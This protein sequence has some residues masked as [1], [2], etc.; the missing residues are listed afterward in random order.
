MAT[1]R[2]RLSEPGEELWNC[3]K[4]Y[5]LVHGPRKGGKSLAIADKLIRNALNYP[6]SNTCI[7]TRTI[8]KGEAG[9][10]RNI[11]K[12]GGMLSKWQKAGL[13]KY[14][15]R[16][17][18]KSGPS[19]RP[20]S[21]VPFFELATSGDPSTF[22]MHTLAED[23]KVEDKFKDQLY[24]F[25]YLVEADSFEREVYT[26]MRMC[27]R[28]T[29]VPY[30]AQQ[31]ILDMNPPAEGKKHWAYKFIENPG[32]DEI[33]IQFPIEKNCFLQPQEREDIRS[34]YAHDPNKLKRF[35]HGEWVEMAEGSCFSDVFNENLHVVGEELGADSDY[36]VL[37][38]MSILR[39]W[40]GSYQYDLG[41]D[42]GD[43]NTS[44]VL[45]SPRQQGNVLCYDILDEVLLLRAPATMDEFVGMVMKMQNYWT[46]WM[47]SEN[48]IHQPM[49]RHWSDSSSM[50]KRMALSGSEAKLVYDLSGGTISLCG[51][52]K[53]RDSVEQRKNMLR[54]LLYENKIA[55]SSRC[56]GIISMLKHLPPKKSKVLRD[57]LSGKDVFVQAGVDGDSRWKHPFDA[58]TY[59]LAQCFPMHLTDGAGPQEEARSLTMNL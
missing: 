37:D 3:R 2:P 24:D 12:P 9:V 7:L 49:F 16:K 1:W 4:R 58:L 21:K 41:W 30:H 40:E 54:R 13:A 44:V 6:G 50:N 48:K 26:T 15:S 53:G 35:F 23:E 10:W 52:T 47:R 39:P 29:V 19:Y 56:T 51:V 28:S 59:S 22:E 14:Y 27:L 45:T 5:I 11:T 38:S 32:D 20:S 18:K 8:A 55:V 17:G 43:Q 33:A 34:T 36:E 42:I 57:D 25:I 31:L 46:A